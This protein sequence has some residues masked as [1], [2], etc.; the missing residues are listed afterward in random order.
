MRSWTIAFLVGTVVLLR[1]PTLPDPMWVQ[2]LPFL[3]ML[4]RH[5]LSGV[6]LGGLGSGYL[7]AAL[8]AHCIVG[9]WL[10]EDLDGRSQVILGTIV[11]LPERNAGRQR[12]VVDVQRTRGVSNWQGRARLTWY[13][14]SGEGQPPTPKAGELWRLPVKLRRPR[15]FSNPVPFDYEAWLFSRGIQA[16]G[17]VLS[18]GPAQRLRPGGLGLGSSRQNLADR[19]DEALGKHP[20]RGVVKALALGFRADI[21]A[22][23]WHLLRTSGTGH[24]VAISGLHIGLVAGAVFFTVSWVWRRFEPLAIRM[25]AERAAACLALV[26]AC[27]Y[28]VLSGFGVPAQRA[29]VMAIAVLAPVLLRLRV[30]ASKSLA[31][32]AAAVLILDP[33][34]TLQPGFWLSFTAVALI[35]AAL[36]LAPR[37]RVRNWRE[38]GWALVKLQCLLSLGLMPLTWFF[39]HQQPLVAPVANLIAVP[40]VSFVCTPLILLG[41]ALM[42]VAGPP[43]AFLVNLGADSLALLFSALGQLTRD[44]LMLRPRV[45]PSVVTVIMAGAGLFLALLPGPCRLR[46]LGMVWCLPLLLQAPP[47]PAQGEFD[48]TVL[49]V[50]QGL[51]VVIETATHVLVYDTGPRFGRG[52]DA[53]ALAVTPFLVAQGWTRIDKIVLS[54]GDLDHAGGLGSLA[55][56]WAQPALI[57][58]TSRPGW[59]A[60]PCEEG[61][62]W[63]WD[64]VEFALFKAELA[65]VRKG[66]D[67]SCVLRVKGKDASVLLP[68]DIEQR[69]ERD[70]VTRI[71]A[72]LRADVLIVPHHGSST[73]STPL[74]LSTVDPTLAVVSRGSGN[75]FKLPHEDVVKR[76]QDRDIVWLDTAELGAIRFRGGPGGLL[77]EP[78]GH[79]QHRRRFWHT[80]PVR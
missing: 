22:D 1:E 45:A 61:K 26:A 21:T 16:T 79:R 39:F 42:A 12:L 31:L 41:T 71:P 63:R 43:A 33:K 20:H 9:N 46:S 7:W 38:R 35:L 64:D 44:D 3:C 62:N 78:A 17:Y 80:G 77:V 14:R 72:E 13:Y 52:T 75:R 23:Q 67:A 53:G 50:G 74:F 29:L 49:E 2:A 24:L 68:G 30:P 57:A 27:S 8:S 6:I 25:P 15:G 40:W 18:R 36:N 59:R 54:H 4:L 34:A 56:R 37:H 5:N 58:N 11:G 73:S 47:R 65:R 60:Q 48:L 70:L 69:A 51:S 32:A 10:P 66:N 76:Y 19:L 28:A 55:R